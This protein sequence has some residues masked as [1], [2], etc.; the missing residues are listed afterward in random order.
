MIA[1]SA[2]GTRL[3][4]VPGTQ[5]RPIGDRVKEALFS[6]LSP[7]LHGC[8]FLDL[9][10]GTGSVGIEALSRGAAQAVFIERD[11]KALQTIRHNLQHTRLDQ[12][13]VIR[14]GDVLRLLQ[15]PIPEPFDLLFLAPPQYRGLW[16]QTLRTLVQA[17]T[18][19]HADSTIIAQI[20]P[21]EREDIKLTCW[22]ESDWRRYGNTA[23]WFFQPLEEQPIS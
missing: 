19:W 2:R 20:D 22:A 5:T 7:Q 11:R 15:R 4:R 1:G 3:R 14:A 9:Y 23:L 17:P 13:A 10:A 18:W 16:S 6:I 12:N 8:R 21:D